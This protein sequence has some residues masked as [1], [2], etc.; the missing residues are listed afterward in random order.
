MHIVRL[1][2]LRWC[3]LKN[4]FQEINKGLFNPYLLI[5]VS[6]FYLRCWFFLCSCKEKIK[7]YVKKNL[8]TPNFLCART[9]ELCITFYAFCRS[10]NAW[11]NSLHHKLIASSS[12]LF[13]RYLRVVY[14]IVKRYEFCQF[15]QLW[16]ILK[17]YIQK[18]L[19]GV[20]CK[21]TTNKIK[22][23]T[24]SRKFTLDHMKCLSIDGT[25]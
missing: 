8:A 16:S 20:A 18:S 10:Q 19:E 23:S 9:E 1:H 22:K 4:I 13:L 2:L 21:H 17:I 6:E 25:F 12:W 3:L 24:S 7:V 14:W 15:W 11:D 5:S